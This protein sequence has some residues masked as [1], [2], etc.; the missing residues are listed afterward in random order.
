[1]DHN[2]N[3]SCPLYPFF[4][5]DK[6]LPRYLICYKF[7]I[8]QSLFWKK[9]AKKHFFIFLKGRY[10]VM[11]AY[12]YECWLV[13]RGFCGLSEKIAWLLFPKY[14]QSYGNLNAKSRNRM[15]LFNFYTFVVLKILDNLVSMQA[16]LNANNC[17]RKQ[18][19]E[20]CPRWPNHYFKC[21]CST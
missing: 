13:L 7:K 6:I 15:A 21:S 16:F 8:E 19:L 11:G 10:F 5:H 20:N 17:W 14:S 18:N 4:K 1:M 9:A 2:F 3:N 12:W